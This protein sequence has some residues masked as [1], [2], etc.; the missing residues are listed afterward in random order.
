MCGPPSHYLPPSSNPVRRHRRRCSSSSSSNSNSSNSRSS[1][2]PQK[3][4]PSLSQERR[5]E[6]SLVIIVPRSHVVSLRAEA[7]ACVLSPPSLPS[8]VFPCHELQY[9]AKFPSQ[10][11]CRRRKI[12]CIPS[13]SDHQGRCVNCIRLKKDC[14]FFPVDQQPPQDTRQK[15]ASR[16]SV[17]SK[18]ASNSSSPALQTG[19]PSDM[20]GQAPYPHLAMPSIQSMA[21]PMKP[22]GSESY[23]P[24]SKCKSKILLWLPLAAPAAPRCFGRS[25]TR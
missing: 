12:R 4:Q 22:S 13:P 11:H 20:H 6:T 15:S 18:M 21:P 5:G 24:E 3:L 17:G 2:P 10:G 1:S 19:L 23:S 9:D 8:P 16:S 25:V 7:A 14:S